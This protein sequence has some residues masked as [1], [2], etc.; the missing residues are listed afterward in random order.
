MI[1]F[2]MV[3]W[4]VAGTASF[5]YWWTSELDLTVGAGMGS[6][7]V[8]FLGPVAFFMGWLIHGKSSQS[9]TV[10]MKARK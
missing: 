3:L 2:L 8:G 9:T 10:L 5:I 6:L 7:V 4:W 1:V